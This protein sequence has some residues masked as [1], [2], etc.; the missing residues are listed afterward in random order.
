MQ[1]RAKKK[2]KK[3]RSPVGP[4]SQQW[5]GPHQWHVAGGGEYVS[6]DRRMKE[7]MKASGLPDLKARRNA[8][9]LPTIGH[10]ISPGGNLD[11]LSAPSAATR[12]QSCALRTTASTSTTPATTAAASTHR[13]PAAHAAAMPMPSITIENDL[14]MNQRNATKER[15]A[16]RDECRQMLSSSLSIYTLATAQFPPLFIYFSNFNLRGKKCVL[17]FFFSRGQKGLYIIN[18]DVLD[19]KKERLMMFVMHYL[20]IN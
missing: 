9:M 16:R 11:R 7:A 12:T 4:T 15:N 14:S 18:Q 20:A 17:S 3:D 10:P 2:K 8:H 13:S 5:C 19:L 1:K 6:T